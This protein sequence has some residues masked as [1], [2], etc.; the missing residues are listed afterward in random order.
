[1]YISHSLKM[2]SAE[3]AYDVCNSLVS[4]QNRICRSYICYG[5]K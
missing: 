1:M 4:R 5:F 2:E 3:S